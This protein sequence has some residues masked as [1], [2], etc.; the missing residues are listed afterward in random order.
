[1][2]KYPAFTDRL[3]KEHGGQDRK[4]LILPKK[5]LVLI[6]KYTVDYIGF[7]YYMSSAC[8]ISQQKKLMKYKVTGWV[9]FVRNPFLEASEW[10]WQIDPEGL[11]IA[12][13]E[14]YDR[15]RNHYLSWKMV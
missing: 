10:G 1:M 15:Y 13:N 14:L 12:L 2:G 11:R 8:G 3:Y 9:V 5:D 6:A 7:S 4:I